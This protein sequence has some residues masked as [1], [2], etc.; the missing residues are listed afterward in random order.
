MSLTL[1]LYRALMG[2]AEPLAPMLLA[3]RAARGK[4]DPARIGERLGRAGIAR[5]DGPLVWLHGVSVGETLSLLALIDRIHAERPDLAILITSGTVTS[6]SLLDRRLPP[7]VI[8]QYAPVDGPAATA[9]F[10]AHWRPDLGILAESDLW[11][12]LITTARASGAKLALVSA[13]LTEK[14]ASGWARRPGAA[15]TLLGAFDLILPQDIETAGRLGALGVRSG[16]LLNLKLLGA[17]LPFDADELKHL[18]ATAKGRQIVI[19]ASTHPGEDEIIASAVPPGLLLVIIP[20]HP[21]RGPAIASAITATGRAVTRRAAGQ[22]LSAANDLYVADTL[23][24]MGLFMRL[25]DLVILGGSLVP[26]IGGHNPLEPARLGAPTISGPYVHKNAELFADMARS[27]AVM[28]AQPADLP[29]AVARLMTD[30]SARGDL[31][32]AGLAYAKHQSGAFEEG[33]ALIRPLLP[34]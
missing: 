20:R 28:I 24:E 18:M 12:N 15:R 33:W 16:P 29:S 27:G 23:G 6:A 17:P 25:A 4:E 10:I 5:P 11:P 19:A 9:R 8:H 22:P 1:G 30:A 21:E 2:L 34:A 7:G 3:R 32:G 14:S 26:G 13:R 31:A